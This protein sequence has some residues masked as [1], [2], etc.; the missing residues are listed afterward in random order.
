MPRHVHELFDI[1][2]ID[3]EP[4]LVQLELHFVK[5]LFLELF[6][7]FK[8]ILHGHGSRKDSSL[9]FDN[10]LHEFVNVV[11]ELVVRGDEP[12][13]LDEAGHLIS[14]GT[15]CEHGREDERELL[16]AHGLNLEGVVDG[17]DVDDG[18]DWPGKIHDF[19]QIFISGIHPPV[20]TR[21]SH[22]LAT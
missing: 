13:V 6:G 4:E 16:S 14:A 9:T 10:S 18:A 8:D 5:H 17:G 7:P 3:Q 19:L 2:V 11:R 21:Y 15:D 1:G 12:G 20:I 22:A